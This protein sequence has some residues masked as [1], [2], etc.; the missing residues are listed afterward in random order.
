MKE[1]VRI[2]RAGFAYR[3]TF[4]RFVQRF[5]LL[6]PATGYAGDYI[7]RGDDISAVKEILKS[8]HIPP[9]EYQLGTTKV[10]IKTPETLFALEDMRD[11]YWHNMAARI[12]RAWRRYVKRK[13]DAAKTIQNAW[14]IKNMVINL[15][16][17]VIM[18]MDYYKVEKNVVVCRC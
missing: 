10:F 8:C 17:S 12:Q 15:S 6:S 3:S 11:K 18:V 2:R 4:E 13:E 1:N 5:Y 7:W 9:S 16:N 14:R